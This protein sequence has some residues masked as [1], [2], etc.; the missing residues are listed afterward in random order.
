[1]PPEVIAIAP[2]TGATDVRA[3][4][5][6]ITFD[7][8]IKDLSNGQT[9]GFDR[10]VQ[11]SPE[12]GPLDIGWH[13]DAITIKGREPF[14]P[15]TA[16]R[17][18]LLPGIVDLHGNVTRTATHTQFST[19]GTFPTLGIRGQA[20]DWQSQQLARDATVLATKHLSDKDSITYVAST[21]TAGR[22]SLGPLPAGAYTVLAFTDPDKKRVLSRTGKWD[23]VDTVVT[24]YQPDLKLMLIQR[25][26]APPAIGA[27]TL[28][29]SLS[30]RIDFTEPLDPAE[31]L[32]IDSLRAQRADSTL[33]AIDSVATVDQD[34]QSRAAAAKSRRD[35]AGAPVVPLPAAPLVVTPSEAA[36]IPPPKPPKPPPYKA[37]VI[38]VSPTTPFLPGMTY[39]VTAAGFRN[40]LG[41]SRVTTRVVSIPRA[42]TKP[43]PP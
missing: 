30:M 26:S 10:L 21:D 7:E 38:Y 35:T 6:R 17:V 19:G 1:M 13:R 34:E 18:T 33:L 36:R 12:V 15:N 37:I 28:K 41:F 22:F 23:R 3:R 5:I 27:L 25:D 42:Q 8:I 31:P 11:V 16:Y 2:D 43:P 9:N 14:R 40:L 29:D 20:W 39:R 32:L 4:E 24:D